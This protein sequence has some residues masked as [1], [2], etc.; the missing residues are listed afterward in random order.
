MYFLL[1][2]VQIL[3]RLESF[4]FR[5]FSCS[6][7]YRLLK[8]ILLMIFNL[9]LIFLF[10]KFDKVIR[11]FTKIFVYIYILLSIFNFFYLRFKLTSFLRIIFNYLIYIL[12]Y[13]ISVF[14]RRK[15]AWWWKIR[16]SRL[17]II[18]F[19]IKIY[20]LLFIILVFL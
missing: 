12:L 14:T 3:K 5:N 2:V 17:T 13:Q 10:S 1:C 8:L 18:L 9:L 6:R 7:R 4:I 11:Q 15:S 19:I 16:N 20:H